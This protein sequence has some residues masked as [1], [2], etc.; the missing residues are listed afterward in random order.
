MKK[1]V[2]EM[3]ESTEFA[4]E[5]GMFICQGCGMKYSVEE[6][7]KL[8]VEVEGDAPAS[9]AAS[10]SSQEKVENL[11]TLAENAIK[12][13]NNTEA[14]SYAS[15]VLEIDP[16]NYLAWR[17]KGEA[18]GWQTKVDN[19]RFVE[20]T[21]CFRNAVDNVPEDKRADLIVRIR[22]Q[23]ENLAEALIDLDTKNF[24]E[25]PIEENRDRCLACSSAVLE[26]ATTLLKM[27]V[28]F[29]V[30]KITQYMADHFNTAAVKGSDYA[31]NN[32]GPEKSSMYYEAYIRWMN[33][34]DYCIDLL[35]RAFIHAQEEKTINLIVK[36]MRI[37]HQGVIDSCC[38]K[39]EAGAYYSDY[40]VDKNLTDAA[41]KSRR[42]EVAKYER[43][44]AKKIKEKKDAEEKERREKQEAAN[45]KYWE[46]HAEEK[47]ELEAK[48]AQL[49]GEIKELTE[50]RKP[51]DAEISKVATEGNATL[52]IETEVE[53]FRGKLDALNRELA[54]LGIFKGKEK[55][56]LREKI[57]AE[58][59]KFI[60]L[61]SEAE[62]KKAEFVKEISDKMAPLRK[63]ADEIN[64]EIAKREKEIKS[65]VTELT[66]DR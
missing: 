60:D 54:S 10:A 26:L 42:D 66:K 56:A 39:F 28:G 8:M 17:I 16:T 4:K 55:K 53:E 40:V 59:L 61:K 35:R 65:I 25:L 20:M 15:K 33:Q 47:A 36:N 44:A 5:E 23:A 22:L 19:I 37:L 6:A 48:K 62:A 34:T 45:R 57:D 12:S 43:D 27:G 30:A 32:Y 51:I 63:E 13:A 2:C 11:L 41:K 38:Y 1:I 49:E 50:K 3:C 52:P 64:A 58:T 7:K 21:N 31:D 14:E 24:G 9:G 29:S 18:V 46:A